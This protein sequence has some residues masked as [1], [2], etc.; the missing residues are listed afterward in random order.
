MNEEI[1]LAK[2]IKKDGFLSLIIPNNKDTQAYE[3]YGFLKCYIKKLEG[4]LIEE[5]E[6]E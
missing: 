2:I 4:D 5:F 6:N 1:V 3:L